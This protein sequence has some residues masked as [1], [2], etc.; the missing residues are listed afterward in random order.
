MAEPQSTDKHQIEISGGYVS[1]RD[2]LKHRIANLSVFGPVVA[3]VGVV[4]LV[5]ELVSG[6]PGIGLIVSAV[7]VGMVVWAKLLQEVLN[8]W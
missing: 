3:V 5:I 4:I 2:Q 6:G 8:R 7:G 1:K